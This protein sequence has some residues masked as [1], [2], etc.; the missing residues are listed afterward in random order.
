MRSKEVEAVI[1]KIEKFKTEKCLYKC[2]DDSDWQEASVLLSYIQ[3]LEIMNLNNTERIRY[4]ERSCDRKESTIIELEFENNCVS[5]DKIRDKIE[6]LE[7]RA[8]EYGYYKTEIEYARN[9]L[10]EILGE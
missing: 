9:T 2:F 7:K 3:Q 8:K 4:L 1:N 10:K 5:K 6:W